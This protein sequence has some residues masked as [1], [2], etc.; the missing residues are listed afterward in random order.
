MTPEQ[1]LKELRTF[2]ASIHAEQ[3][4]LAKQYDEMQ[5]AIA[6]LAQPRSLPLAA[7]QI[8]I[9][10]PLGGQPP[11]ASALK[12]QPMVRQ[13]TKAS[14]HTLSVAMRALW[15]KRRQEKRQL[16]EDQAAAHLDDRLHA[17]RGYGSVTA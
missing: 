7:R 14:R 12:T 10:P 4:L 16:A 8:A 9:R 5:T 15:A 3:V 6:I 11:V 2:A 13:W 17:I 1:V